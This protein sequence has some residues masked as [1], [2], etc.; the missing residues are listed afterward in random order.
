[1]L[2]ALRAAD[3]VALPASDKLLIAPT[4]TKTADARLVEE[5]LR[6]AVP[7][8]TAGVAPYRRGDTAD[9]LL[10]VPNKPPPRGARR[11]PKLPEKPDGQPRGTVKVRRLPGLS[12]F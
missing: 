7:N 9:D 12:G 5:R 10:S 2:D 1:V 6:V 8:A 11:T 3:L 4:N